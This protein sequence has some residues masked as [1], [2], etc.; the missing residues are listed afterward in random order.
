MSEVRWRLLRQ[1]NDPNPAIMN[2]ALDESIMEAV[3]KGA[4][5]PTLRF[6]RWRPSAV[7][8]GYFQGM[9]ME[10]DVPACKEKGIEAIR[11][12]TGGG[13]VYHDEAGEVTYS[14]CVPD[15]G[16]LPSDIQG[17]YRAICDGLI[18]GLGELGIFASFRPLNDIV[19]G[20]RKISGN[21]QTRRMGVI[22]QHGTILLDVDPEKMF[23]VLKV[24][25]EK[26]KGKII[27]SIKG[28][29]TSIREQLGS[30]PPYSDV[31]GALQK[32]I[33]Q[34]LGIDPILGIP[35]DLELVRAR[36]IAATRYS[37]PEWN[38]RR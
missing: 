11:R 15:R 37:R 26:M 2:M 1:E 28:S 18:S 12:I 6:Y 33:G 34:S 32:G 10:I 8:I 22:L 31:A 23:S 38:F 9:D 25:S 4:S 5:P 17:S 36:E 3:S 35:T 7:S 24:P 20:A 16:H 30:L 29:V 27:E 19:V 14:V 13:A 21:A